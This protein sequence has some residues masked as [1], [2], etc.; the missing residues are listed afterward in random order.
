[1]YLS[2]VTIPPP[3][4][5]CCCCRSHSTGLTP[6]RGVYLSGATMSP[7]SRA[8]AV[9]RWGLCPRCPGRGVHFS[10]VT[11][12]PPSR[13]WGLCPHFPGWEVYL[14]G[15]GYNPLLPYARR[16]G[17]PTQKATNYTAR[18]NIDTARFF[19]HTNGQR[20]KR[21]SIRQRSRRRQRR[22]EPHTE[23][24]LGV[25]LFAAADPI[26]LVT[27]EV[28]PP[29]VPVP[30]FAIRSY[31]LPLWLESQTSVPVSNRGGGEFSL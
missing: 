17:Q 24:G 11:M 13:S 14:S 18:S 10:G 7:P 8:A 23:H 25:L 22:G 2:G 20:P 30:I 15:N 27:I 16:M 21:A 19:S 31:A 6:G 1:V 4:S 5:R 28:S 12:P 3:P 9:C 29:H 26:P